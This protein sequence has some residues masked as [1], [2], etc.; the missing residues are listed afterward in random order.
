MR[1]KHSFDLSER[2]HSSSEERKIY[3]ENKARSDAESE[4]EK[5]TVARRMK[6]LQ[7]EAEFWAKKELNQ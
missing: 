5:I 4:N 2:R 3:G 1:G 7:D 6:L